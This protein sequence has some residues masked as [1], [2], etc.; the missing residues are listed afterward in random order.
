MTDYM[1]SFISKRMEL[2]PQSRIISEEIE[3]TY[4]SVLEMAEKL[5]SKLNKWNVNNYKL[6]CAVLCRD[7]FYTMLGIL[8]AWKAGMIPIPM[9]I[10]YG[11]QHC[12]KIMEGTSP[13]LLVTDDT[14]IT[15]QFLVPKFDLKTLEINSP[16]LE[17][18]NED[19]DDIAL[20]MNTSGTT[21]NPKGALIRDDGLVANVIAISEYFRI[22]Q[23]DTILI[24]RPIYHCAVLSGEMLISLHNGVNI[25]FS[26]EAYSPATVI[27]IIE[28]YSISVMCGT[29]T[30]FTHLTKMC[31]RIGK[32]NILKVIALSGECLNQEIA[33][34]IRKLFEDTEIYN[35]YGLTEAS[36]RVSYLPPELFDTKSDSVGIGLSNVR[37]IIADGNG[38]EVSVNTPGMVMV[39]SPSIMKGYYRQPE[40]TEKRIVN[41]WLI[42]GDIGYMDESGCLYILS[43]ADDMIIKA[44]MNIYPK[45][46]ENL[47]IQFEF[48]REVVAYGIKEKT[49]QGIAV[50]IV[51]NKGY[52]NLS[53]REMIKAISEKLQSYMMP[54][55]VSVVNELKKNASGK[56]IRKRN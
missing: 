32:R 28:K 43:R 24:A 7:G 16:V 50:D 1:W 4:A 53:S 12:M 36:P 27:G 2:Y 26:N 44:G 10:N 9:S 42:T 48:V 22:N 55:R 30:L 11:E 52:E 25:C 15:K 23:N 40:L 5:G 13:D 19:L 29:P 54:S 20:I 47:L 21:G 38:I 51:L 39:S 6:K 18:A 56:I 35:V 41:G 45:E 46:I 14:E 33:L 49:G 37:I 8:A 3:Y 34:E 31:S 17:R